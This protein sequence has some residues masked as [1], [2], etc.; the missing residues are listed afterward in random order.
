MFKKRPLGF[1]LGAI[2]ACVMLVANIVFILV[3]RGDRTFSWITAILIL[4][5]VLGEALVI[6][7]NPV[8]APLIPAICYGVALSMHLYL[9]LPTLSDVVNGVNF[10]G[11]NPTAVLAFGGIF[12]V[13]TV[14]ALAASFMRQTEKAK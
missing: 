6:G 10:V 14:L 13:G 7:K 8:F 3:D 4:V 5:G 11:G 1:W 9:G 12:L 2:A